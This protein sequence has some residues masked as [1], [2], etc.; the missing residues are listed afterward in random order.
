VVAL[1]T[2][3]PSALAQAPSSLSWVREPGAESCIAAPELGARIERLVGPVLVAPP[4]ALVSVEGHV[5]RRGRRY[6]ARVVVSDARGAVLGERD[7]PGAEA[8]HGEEPDCRSLDDQLAFV[9]AVAIDPNAALAEL[10][11]DLAPE[12]D[13]GRDLL[14]DL[15]AHPPKPASPNA[16]VQPS[17]S[18]ANSRPPPAGGPEPV[19]FAAGLGVGAEAG[20]LPAASALARLELGLGLAWFTQRVFAGLSSAQTVRATEASA[21]LGWLE[22]GTIGCAELLGGGRFA[23]EPCLGLTAARV[24][25][26]PV[27]FSGTDRESWLLGPR[28]ELRLAW[29]AFGPVRVVVRAAISSLLPKNRIV[30]EAG[31]ATR[32]VF[33]VAPVTA[34]AGLLIELR[35]S[36]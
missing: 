12:G 8:A 16:S 35:G 10:P 34:G 2:E 28:A 15:E 18:P 23:L 14:A 13:P 32:R 6:E 26:A 20:A 3:V 27:G 30:F 21:E 9:I 33:E 5:A 4:L 25:G 1:L 29:T 36:P 7:V 11:G 24:T 22:L 17:S 19:H 31:G